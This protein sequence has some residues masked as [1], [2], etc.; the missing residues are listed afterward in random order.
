MHW[1]YHIKDN[2]YQDLESRDCSG[3]DDHS[4][5]DL[6]DDDYDAN[7]YLL[8]VRDS[9]SVYPGIEQ[10]S[11]MSNSEHKPIPFAGDESLPA[12]NSASM[13]TFHPP[14]PQLPNDKS[15]KRHSSLQIPKGFA[16]LKAGS[17]GRVVVKWLHPDHEEKLVNLL[18]V[19]NKGAF[20]VPHYF[21]LSKA[22]TLFTKLGLRWIVVT[23]SPH[24]DGGCQQVV[25]I[26]T[27]HN[28]TADH[29]VG[30]A[31]SKFEQKLE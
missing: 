25:G 8:S 9:M 11:S 21:P 6:E 19:M 20:S 29:I 14:S 30:R 27:R 15:F 2:R 4:V 24:S 3:A 5:D 28:L 16:K 18:A 13:P 10:R 1:A 12:L 31:K 7:D 22:Y 17:D 26:L 23:G